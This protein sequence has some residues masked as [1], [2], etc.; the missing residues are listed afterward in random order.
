MPLRMRPCGRKRGLHHNLV[1]TGGQ[2]RHQGKHALKSLPILS[3]AVG[4]TGGYGEKDEAGM[5]TIEVLDQNMVW[6]LIRMY[7]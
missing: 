4:M 5:Q 3:L 6:L 7:R 1:L 2:G